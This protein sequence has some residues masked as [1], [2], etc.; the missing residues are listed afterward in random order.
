MNVVPFAIST[1]NNILCMYNIRRTMYAV[2]TTDY[3]V[4]RNKI[5]ER[6]TYIVCHTTY[7]L[8]LILIHVQPYYTTYNVRRT[9][10]NVRCTM[11]VVHCTLYNV[12][13]KMYVVQCT[14]YIVR[15]TLYVVQRMLCTKVDHQWIEY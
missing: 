12:R 1:I 5:Y 13:C 3:N 2:H 4:W 8:P 7:N 14:L 15:C 10:Y 11:Y 9:L 6:R